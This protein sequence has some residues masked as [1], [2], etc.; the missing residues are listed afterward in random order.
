[1]QAK[2]SGVIVNIASTAAFGPT[3]FMAAYGATKAFV[4][5]F[6]E[7]LWGENR[8]TRLNS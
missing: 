7:A 1:V 8:S 6:T 3:P 2:G 4:L 5:S